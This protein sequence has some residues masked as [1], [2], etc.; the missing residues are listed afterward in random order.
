MRKS[1]FTEAQ[2]IAIVAR[3]RPSTAARKARGPTALGGVGADGARRASVQPKRDQRV[4]GGVRRG[5]GGGAIL[6]RIAIL[7]RGNPGVLHASKKC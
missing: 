5:G 4:V 7:G 1:R 3:S 2:S 6:G